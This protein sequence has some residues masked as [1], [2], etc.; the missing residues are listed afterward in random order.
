MRRPLLGAGARAR[1]ECRRRACVAADVQEEEEEGVEEEDDEVTVALVV[2]VAVVV[3]VGEAGTLVEA[4]RRRF[5]T[6]SS[7][8]RRKVRG[9]RCAR[10]HR[11]LASPSFRPDAA[12]P[13]CRRRSK[14]RSRSCG[15]PFRL[16]RTS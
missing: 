4:L 14:Q 10:D 9:L 12:T 16:C 3:V 13:T 11:A 1:V 7:S 8:M 6:S 2:G 5:F 15:T